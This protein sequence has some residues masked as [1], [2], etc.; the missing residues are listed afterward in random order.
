MDKPY[1]AVFDTMFRYEWEC[2]IPGA[3]NLNIAKTRRIEMVCSE[4]P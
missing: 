4:V 1:L 3:K 2:K